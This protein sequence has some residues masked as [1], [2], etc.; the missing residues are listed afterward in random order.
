MGLVQAS[1]SKPKEETCVPCPDGYWPG[2]PGTFEEIHKKVKDMHPRNFE[3]ARLFVRKSLSDYFN[4]YH[5]ISLSSF[6]PSGYKFGACY[7]G[8]KH[9]G[10]YERYPLISGDIMPNGNLAA[11]FAHT[12]GCRFRIKH[13]TQMVK[14]KCVTASST[15]EYRS[16]D[17]TLSL[18]IADPDIMKQSGTFVLHYLQALSS[19]LTLG[20]EIAIHR[21]KYVPGGQQSIMTFAARYSSGARTLAATFGQVGLHVSYHHRA[22]QQLQLGVE[23]ESNLRTL[24]STATLIYELDVPHA[25]MIFRGLVNTETTIGGVF[26]KKL[27]PMPET[28]LVLSGMLNHRKQQLRVGIGLNIG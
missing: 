28:S 10:L 25:D 19:R 12:I 14:G 21:S 4:A 17:S 20:T 9:I 27:Y 3:G 16:D 24:D 22:S 2:N 8:S 5:T 7:K 13:V 23:L 1:V 6:M 11:S 15:A 18:I 26:E